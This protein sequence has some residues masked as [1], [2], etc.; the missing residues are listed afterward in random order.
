MKIWLPLSFCLSLNA[1]LADPPIPLRVEPSLFGAGEAFVPCTLGGEEL[2]CKLDTGANV[3]S[4]RG[5]ASLAGLPSLGSVTYRTV[6]GASETCD[7]VKTT[8][9]VGPLEKKDFE[10]LR[11]PGAEAAAPKILLGL[12]FFS[13]HALHFDLR[14]KALELRSE[15]DAL[16]QAFTEDS[17]GHALLPVFLKAKMDDDATPA[18]ALFDTGAAITTVSHSFVKA[19]P[20]QFTLLSANEVGKDS[21]G[22][23]IFSYLMMASFLDIGGQ[24]VVAPY[25]FAIDLDV[26]SELAG[27]KIDLILGFN[28][29]RE[30]GWKF[31]F[32]QKRWGTEP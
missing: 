24:V 4:A 3:S 8:L 1:A 2:E 27:Q 13:A 29:I 18:L 9:K 7:Y 25:V 5:L 32:R 10:L 22:Q 16:P 17:Y 31:D 23:P 11:C 12:D 6:S 21:L 26:A 15:D 30:L 14:K 28:V 20:G 19:H